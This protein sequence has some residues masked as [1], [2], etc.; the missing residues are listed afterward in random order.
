MYYQLNIKVRLKSFLRKYFKSLL[1]KRVQFFEGEVMITLNSFA[2]EDSGLS[3][4]ASI[5]N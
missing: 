1:Y 5:I 2:T 3:E 4:V